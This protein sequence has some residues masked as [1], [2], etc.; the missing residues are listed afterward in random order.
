MT[1]TDHARNAEQYII[2]AI[3]ELSTFGLEAEAQTED[4][5]TVVNALDDCRRSLETLYNAYKEYFNEATYKP[6]AFRYLRE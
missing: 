2:D 1:A 4:A 6:I 5:E 3:S